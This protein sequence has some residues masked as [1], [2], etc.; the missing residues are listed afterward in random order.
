MQE[1]IRLATEPNNSTK[2]SRELL[3]K[4]CVVSE[5]YEL[6]HLQ[7]TAYFLQ[8]RE[9]VERRLVQE[10]HQ[11]QE[12]VPSMNQP[13]SKKAIFLNKIEKEKSRKEIA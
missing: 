10:S 13:V 7:E 9:R 3:E 6:Q 5:E 2:E 1:S 8:E 11:Q 4:V 12:N